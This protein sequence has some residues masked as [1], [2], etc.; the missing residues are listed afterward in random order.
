MAH[1]LLQLVPA[2][3]RPAAEAMAKQVAGDNNDWALGLLGG[4][5]TMLCENLAYAVTAIAPALDR[6]RLGVLTRFTLWTFRLDNLLDDPATPVAELVA[7]EARLAEA[8]RTRESSPADAL[9]VTLLR[10][11]DALDGDPALLDSLLDDIA[12][13]V[14]HATLSRR[15]AAGECA[16][17]PA[18]EYLAVA[19]RSINYRSV[20][21][22]LLLLEAPWAGDR[23]RLDEALTVGCRAIRLAND[24]RSVERHRREGALNVLLLRDRAGEPVTRGAVEDQI[25]R[26]IDRHDALLSGGTSSERAL[27]NGLRVSVGVYRVGQLR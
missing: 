2:A 24:L 13:T 22:A 23:G 9:A 18:E 25:D 7:I 17:P 26:L 14:A 27:V 12:G 21:V 16:A 8:L 4:T 15:V 5:G 20:A 11:I 1:P 19:S 6:E 3:E 10:L